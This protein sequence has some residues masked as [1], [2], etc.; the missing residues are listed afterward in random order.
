MHILSSSSSSWLRG[1]AGS[2]CVVCHCHCCQ[3]LCHCCCCCLASV[4]V[5]SLWHWPSALHHHRLRRTGMDTLSSSWRCRIGHLHR[6]VIIFVKLLPP[7]LPS[8]ALATSMSHCRCHRHSHQ[9]SPSLSSSLLL[10]LLCCHGTGHVHLVI[11]VFTVVAWTHCCVVHHCHCCH[12]CIVCRHCGDTVEMMKRKGTGT[13]VWAWTK[14]WAVPAS[15]T[16]CE[17][18]Y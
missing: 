10:L 8:P 6:V 13:E 7:P 5:V 14:R 15:L 12:C 16:W 17:S 3:V 1:H 18:Y 4:V 11:L 9:S 2:C